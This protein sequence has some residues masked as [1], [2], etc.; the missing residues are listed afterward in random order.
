MEI[1]LGKGDELSKKTKLILGLKEDIVKNFYEIGKILKEV[2]DKELYLAKY[3][4]FEQ[5][6]EE[7][8][9]FS[10]RSAYRYMQLTSIDEPEHLSLSQWDLVLPLDPQKR[11]VALTK[12]FDVKKSKGSI[13]TDEVREI[14][15]EVKSPLNNS[16]FKEFWDLEML[17]RKTLELKSLLDENMK[18][19][20]IRYEALKDKLSIY[21]N[22]RS[23]I[24]KHHLLNQVNL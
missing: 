2:K 11:E 5:Y 15:A 10:R 21:P 24:E 14:V 17:Q 3:Q 22:A 20:F 13:S 9:Q 4:F 18:L 12:V 8:C 23:I 19:C 6:L 7:E 1:V 16:D